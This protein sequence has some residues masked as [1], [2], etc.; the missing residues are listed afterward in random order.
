MR[1][2]RVERTTKESSVLVE[3]NLDGSGEIRGVLIRDVGLL[4]YLRVTIGNV[5][6]NKKFIDSLSACLGVEI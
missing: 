5:A 3:L 2:A 4:G 1:T 6:E